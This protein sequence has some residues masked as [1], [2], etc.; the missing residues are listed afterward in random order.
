[1]KVKMLGEFVQGY[2]V[3]RRSDGKEGTIVDIV[4]D[5]GVWKVII[6]TK[7]DDPP[8]SMPPWEAR[9]IWAVEPT[10]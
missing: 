4:D 2:S 3:R 10:R 9:R 7:D 6:A 8:V 5:Q 1:M